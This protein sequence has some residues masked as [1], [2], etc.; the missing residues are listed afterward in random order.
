MTARSY[1]SSSFGRGTQ[2][3]DAASALLFCEGLRL[4]GG[5]LDSR[6]GCASPSM[7]VLLLLAVLPVLTFDRR[8]FLMLAPLFFAIAEEDDS[9]S[10]EIPFEAAG[11]DVQA[12]LPSPLLQVAPVRRSWWPNAKL[13]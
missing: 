2:R 1:L 12:G 9:K 4:A 3:H 10:R 11:E 13:K 7:P 8:P 5:P 6:A